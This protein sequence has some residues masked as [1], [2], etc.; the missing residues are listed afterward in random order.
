M[1]Y[2][3]VENEGFS[4]ITALVDGEL[5]VA[6]SEHPNYKAIL[7]AVVEGVEAGLSDLFDV[8]KAVAKRFQRIS[9]RVTV[10]AGQVYFDGELVDNSL[11]K[12]ILRFMDDG[13]E[14][15]QPLVNF[16]EKVATNPQEHSRE[17]L[18]RWLQQHDF[19]IDADG[20]IIAYK[21]VRVGSD[22]VY[23]SISRG[24]AVVNGES[25]NGYVPNPLGATV[26]M[27]RNSVA[28]NPSVGCS[29]GLHAGTWSYAKGFAQGA[30]LKVKINPRDVV[31][32]P[33]DCADQKVR[34]CRYRVLEV[35][36]TEITSSYYRSDNDF[37][38]G[39]DGDYAEFDSPESSLVEGA[40]WEDGDLTVAIKYSG[41]EYV[42]VDVPRSVF[43]DFKA[44]ESKG[45]F[46]NENIKGQY[47]TQVS[48]F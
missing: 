40:C 4:S 8:S 39:P 9:E 3:L 22:G 38:E 25:V 45:K 5:L 43:N 1:R 41:S 26:E 20:D 37:V 35:T 30:V 16:F 17:Q 44:S 12:Q 29:T 15:F 19:P 42:Y 32:V 18:F 7:S 48:Y 47:D 2:T 10:A 46:Y 28:W 27:P 34:V 23:T 36:Q 6:T 33:T 13:E 21:G 14:D 24:P 11:T 31:S